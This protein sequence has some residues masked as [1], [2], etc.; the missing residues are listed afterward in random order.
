MSAVYEV[1]L[2]PSAIPLMGTHYI[3]WAP[4]KYTVSMQFMFR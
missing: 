1:T 2:P 3:Y 4:L